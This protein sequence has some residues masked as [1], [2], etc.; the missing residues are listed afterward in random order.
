MMIFFY[1]R[2]G[3]K[4]GNLSFFMIYTYTPTYTCTREINICVFYNMMK[5]HTDFDEMNMINV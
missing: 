1:Y 4:N 2:K 5:I 3:G